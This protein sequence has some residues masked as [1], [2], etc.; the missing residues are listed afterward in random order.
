MILDE[1]MFGNLNGFK[2]LLRKLQC[3]SKEIAM[4]L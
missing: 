2:T 4:S 3:T 1:K